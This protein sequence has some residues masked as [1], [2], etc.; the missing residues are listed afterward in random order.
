VRA[1]TLHPDYA[2]VGDGARLPLGSWQPEGDLRGI[3]LGLH[4]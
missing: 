1:P 2:I 4:G 3:V